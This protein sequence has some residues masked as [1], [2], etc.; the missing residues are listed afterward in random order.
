MEDSEEYFLIFHVKLENYEDVQYFTRIANSSDELVDACT[1]FAL[2]F[3]NATLDPE[4]VYP[5]TQYL[6]Q[7][8]SRKNTTLA[9]VDIHSR[10]KTVIWDGMSVK[11]I[12]G[13]EITYLELENDVISLKLDYQVSYENESGE[14]E[15]YQVK[16][17]FRIRHTNARMYLLDYERTTERLFELNHQVF[18]EKN[19]NLG[20]Q[21]K[22]VPYMSNEEG[23]VVNFVVSD[24]LWSYDIAQNKLSKVFSF[25]N[26]SDRRG[27]HDEFEIQ[28]VNMEDSG[29]MDFVVMGYM[30]RGFHE[31]QTG[32]AVMRY[33]SLTNTTE[34]LLFI[35]GN[36]CFGVLSKTVGELLYISFDEKMYLSYGG[37][38]YAIDLNMKTVET[39]T[40]NL[41]A[42]N[43][44]ISRAGD[45]IAWQHGDD[46]YASTQITTMDMKNGMRKTYKASEGEYIRP[47]GFSGSDFIYG[48]CKESDMVE[49][50]AGNTMF[51]MYCVKIV[52]NKGESIRDFVE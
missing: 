27:L 7:D 41:S 12:Q 8:T 40:E 44:L 6:E 23:S 19:L 9:K 18:G 30:N 1:Q 25:K 10:Y 22:E 50:F 20:I 3:H 48:V 29:S 47:L 42:E 4:N 24:E 16:D 35:E 15:K 5:L 2:E 51:P 49:D 26:G 13:P 36:E 11:E 37:D 32:V 28:L 43:Y 14:D 21:W 46:K 38:I 17:Y 33:D 31:G 52:N 45:M 39:L 34:E